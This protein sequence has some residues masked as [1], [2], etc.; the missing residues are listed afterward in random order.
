MIVTSDRPADVSISADSLDWF[1]NGEIVGS[2]THE[3]DPPVDSG[4]SVS[5]TT[6]AFQAQTTTEVY[7]DGEL[8]SQDSDPDG[9][10]L[11]NC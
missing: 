5:A 1:A 11:V 3:R 10:A 7:E 8:V 4:L 2:K 6:Q 9:F